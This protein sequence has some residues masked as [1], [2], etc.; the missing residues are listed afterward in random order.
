MVGLKTKEI[1]LP[2]P[3]PCLWEER[4]LRVTV[5]MP[6]DQTETG[7]SLDYFSFPVLQKAARSL[8]GFPSIL[9]GF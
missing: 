5:A 6:G 1:G 7:S 9:L 8:G 4:G 3:P 2:W